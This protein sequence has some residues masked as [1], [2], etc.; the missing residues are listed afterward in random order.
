[1]GSPILE[2]PSAIPAYKYSSGS[3]WGP[4]YFSPSPNAAQKS[5]QSREQRESFLRFLEYLCG[6]RPKIEWEEYKRMPQDAVYAGYCLASEINSSFGSPRQ[7][8]SVLERFRFEMNRCEWSYDMVSVVLSILEE[9][10]AQQAAGQIPY[11]QGQVSAPPLVSQPASL[12]LNAPVQ[13]GG[14]KI[15]VAEQPLPAEQE[16]SGLQPVSTR[17]LLMEYFKKYPSDFAPVMSAVLQVREISPAALAPLLIRKASQEGI[18]AISGRALLEIKRKRKER[19][20]SLLLGLFSGKRL[21]RPDL[22]S[23]LSLI[24]KKRQ[25]R[26]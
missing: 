24:V 17:E 5:L 15:K 20:E 9:A 4:I 10:G 6:I 18:A 13:K 1:M 21:F 23:I 11:A 19:Y 7:R 2:L 22:R 3:L 12:L 14:A 8:E 16:L 26:K 25:A